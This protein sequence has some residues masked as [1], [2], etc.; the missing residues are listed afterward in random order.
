MRFTDADKML[1]SGH[2]NMPQGVAVNSK[3]TVYI[4]DMM[5]HAVQVFNSEGEFQFRFGK[6]GTG[7]GGNN[8]TVGYHY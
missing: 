7:P 1:G 8:F 2:L 6:M 4:V 3:G 5:N